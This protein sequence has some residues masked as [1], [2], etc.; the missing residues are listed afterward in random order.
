MLFQQI[1]TGSKPYFVNRGHMEHFLAHRHPEVELNYCIS[2]TCKIRINNHMYTMNEG[3]IALIGSMVS[4]EVPA[5]NV[6]CQA[7]T[8]EAGSVLLK[9]Q[10]A[11]FSDIEF[12][13]PVYQLENDDEKAVR[14]RE[15]IGE[16]CMEIAD[17]YTAVSE[18]AKLQIL[19]NLYKIYAYVLEEI[20][21]NRNVRKRPPKDFRAVENVERALGL[22]YNCYS[23]NIS[24]ED[25]AALTGYN[26]SNFCKIFKSM[27]GDSFH[28]VLNQYRIEMAGS[29]LY[30]T[31]QSIEEIAVAVGFADAKAFGR[32]FKSQV[33]ITPGQYRKAKQSEVNFCE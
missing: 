24:V 25:A 30:E 4:H 13:Q 9:D 11:Y 3:D 2:G 18:P 31:K 5:G 33:G 29:L 22:I 23:E 28:Q 6:F 15:K 19:G 20:L 12:I 27:T 10:F 1:L 17:N 21:T 7:L 26:K 14:F 32:V 16:L 8:L